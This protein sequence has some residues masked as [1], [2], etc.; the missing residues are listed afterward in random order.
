MRAFIPVVVIASLVS[1]VSALPVSNGLS[2]FASNGT[3][4]FCS[5]WETKCATACGTS[6]TAVA[7][8][9]V[10]NAVLKRGSTSALNCK[11]GTKDITSTVLTSTFKAMG[12]TTNTTAS[13]SSKGSSLVQI[14]G[15][16]SNGTSTASA[17]N[18]SSTGTSQVSDDTVSAIALNFADVVAATTVA[19]AVEQ[20]PTSTAAAASAFTLGA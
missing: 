19:A 5:R 2:L 3:S 13:G 8:C 12:S 20:A 16:S 4:S 10:N 7:T 6:G 17:A 9:K 14:V 18:T 15:L 11:C 1:A